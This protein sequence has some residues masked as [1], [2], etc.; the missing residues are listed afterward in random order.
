MQSR[1]DGFN[2]WLVKAVD[3]ALLNIPTQI[4]PHAAILVSQ[5]SVVSGISCHFSEFS[6]CRM[7]GHAKTGRK[8][9]RRTPGKRISLK[10]K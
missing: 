10:S 6:I 5:H 1:L 8:C 2:Q 7:T 9:L 4:Q 3:A